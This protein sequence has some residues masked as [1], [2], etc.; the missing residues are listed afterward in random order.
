[1]RARISM[2]RAAA[3][4]LGLALLAPASPARSRPPRELRSPGTVTVTL[5]NG[6]TATLAR[7]DAI[8][9]E[10]SPCETATVNNTDDIVIDGS[11]SGRT[12]SRSTCPA[13]RS[14]WR[15][16]EDAP[17]THRVRGRPARRRPSISGRDG[18]DH[19]TIGAGART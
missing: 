3:A 16:A 2:P 19:V 10:G 6:A 5:T 1:M 7:G 13:A 17:T 18:A 11:A 12:T 9:L 15:G 14:A 8:A 4:A